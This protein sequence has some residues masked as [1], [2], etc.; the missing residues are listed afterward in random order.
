[1]LARFNEK[2]MSFSA[3]IPSINDAIFKCAS[4][5]YEHNYVQLNR[6]YFT[7]SHFAH[8]SK[9]ALFFLLVFTLIGMELPEYHSVNYVVM[10]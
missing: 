10:S 3:N 5:N 1:M 7:I 2:E 6:V 8:L 4:I 9:K